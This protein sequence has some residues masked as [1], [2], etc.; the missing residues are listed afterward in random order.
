MFVIGH[1]RVIVH[2]GDTVLV[3]LGDDAC[4]GEMALLQEETRNADITAKSYCDLY[5]L[6][7]SA[8]TELIKN[9]KDLA[10]NALR[11]VENR[12]AS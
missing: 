10:A 3:E 11:I 2:S 4:F 7:K 8:F 1:G 9:H 5:K 12:L 6:P